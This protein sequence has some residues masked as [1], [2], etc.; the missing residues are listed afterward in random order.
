M[1]KTMQVPLLDLKRYDPDYETEVMETF[2]RVFRS[3]YFILGPEVAALE[4]ECAAYI[5]AKHAVGVSSGTDALILSLMALNAT[6][7]AC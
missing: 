1:T 7:V 4:K 2:R 6:S 3:G 5:G